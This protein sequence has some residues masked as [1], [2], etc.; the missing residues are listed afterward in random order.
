MKVSVT[1]T[2]HDRNS[3]HIILNSTTEIDIVSAVAVEIDKI[4]RTACGIVMCMN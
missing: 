2:I 3:D 1:L 4:R